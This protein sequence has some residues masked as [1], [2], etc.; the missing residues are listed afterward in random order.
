MT[1]P[2]TSIA[3]EI[4]DEPKPGWTTS[5][6]ITTVLVHALSV[7]AILL[8]ML[9]VN[10]KQGLSSAEAAVP[11]LAVAIS[12]LLQAAYSDHRTKLKVQHLQEL[13]RVR[14][15]QIEKEIMKVETVATLVHAPGVIQQ[16]NT[17]LSGPD[18]QRLANAFATGP[19]SSPNEITDNRQ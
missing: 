11:V 17:D 13:A 18:G 14:I 16:L 2:S 10:W 19:I 1:D 6:F 5:E 3:A 7:V 8:D 4:P 9:H 12:A 15:V